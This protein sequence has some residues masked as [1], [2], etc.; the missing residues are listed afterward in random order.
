MAMKSA[1]R[2]LRG[3]RFN[4]RNLKLGRL[5]GRVVFSAGIRRIFDEF[6]NWIDPD[7]WIGKRDPA[8]EPTLLRGLEG[9]L[10]AGIPSALWSGKPSSSLITVPDVDNGEGAW[11]VVTGPHRAT[12]GLYTGIVLAT[13]EDASR[14]LAV[15]WSTR[16]LVL[17]RRESRSSSW[18]Q[19]GSVPN[20]RYSPGDTIRVTRIRTETGYIISVYQNGA[21]QAAWEDRTGLPGG[22][23]TQKVGVRLQGDRSLF[24]TSESPSIDS[25]QFTTEVT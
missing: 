1:G 7:L 21:R 24:T 8:A 20:F 11:E 13:D 9:Y 17:R 19:L 2:T 22:R 18:V 3:G 10:R 15:E 6:V 5:N 25:F 12:A 14:M 23:G 4:G 16:E